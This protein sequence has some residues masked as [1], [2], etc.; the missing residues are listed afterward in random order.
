[1]TASSVSPTVVIGGEDA[2]P[3]VAERD[4]VTRLHLPKP[5]P[6]GGDRLEQAA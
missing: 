1:V 4:E 5:H 6:S 3:Q 2:Y